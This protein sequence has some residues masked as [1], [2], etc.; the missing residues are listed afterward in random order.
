MGKIIDFIEKET[1]GKCFTSYKY[2]YDDGS[3]PVIEYES[4][5]DT[6]INLKEYAED[7]KD[8]KPRDMSQ[9]AR[10]CMQGPPLFKFFLDGSRKVYKLDDIQ[11]DKK[12]FPII[13]G[14][15]S[16]SCCGRDSDEQGRYVG[17]HCVAESS[18][19]ALCLPV[20]ANGEGI[21]HNVF[22]R[23]LAEKIKSNPKLYADRVHLEKILFYKTKL[24]GHETL[25]NKGIARIQDEMVDCEKR[26]V[27]ELMS[28]HLLTQES[29]LIKDGSIQYKPMKTGDFKELARIRNNYRHVVGVSKKFN[30][31]LMRDNKDQSN[32]GAIARLPLYHRTPAFL[33]RP[34][35]EW[36]NVTFAIWYVRIHDRKHTDTPYSGIVKI[37]K[38]LMTGHEEEYGLSTDEIDTITANIINER[39]PVCYG[40][41][42]RWANHLYPV[43]MTECYCKS[44]FASDYYFMNIF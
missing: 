42:A 19:S 21:D 10:I 4:D 27:S 34:G 6:Y 15:I 40:S 7:C 36:G 30:P 39:N 2:S 16:V 8:P 11:Y 12:V 9:R 33:W 13:G 17:F 23:N 25:E 24:E 41:D 43:Y 22:F 37:E 3:M 35:E 28:R 1:D 32:A 20:T 31:N 14:Q 38:M 44:R 29:Y 18:Y 5:E 26:I